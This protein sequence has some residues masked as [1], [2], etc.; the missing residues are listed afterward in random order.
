MPVVLS[1]HTKTLISRTTRKECRRRHRSLL[2]LERSKLEMD[3]YGRVK[4]FSNLKG[5][6]KKQRK[7]DGLRFDQEVDLGKPAPERVFG[8]MPECK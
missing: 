6:K 8:E 3:L 5:C 2:G 7:A 4:A 1:G